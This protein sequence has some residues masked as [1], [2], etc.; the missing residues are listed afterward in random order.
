M[1]VL[2]V[3][4]RKDGNIQWKPLNSTFIKSTGVPIKVASSVKKSHGG[5]KK[6]FT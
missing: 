6:K 3:W 5:K 2:G 1:L 4:A